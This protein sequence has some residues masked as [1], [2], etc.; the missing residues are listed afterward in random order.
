MCTW[1]DLISRWI[2][3]RDWSPSTDAR[4]RSSRTPSLSR[5]TTVSTLKFQSWS[6]EPRACSGRLAGALRLRRYRPRQIY[7]HPERQ[8]REQQRNELRGR[9]HEHRAALVAAVEL[10]DEARDGVEEHVE[11]ERAARERTPFAFGP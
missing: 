10:D 6:A 7:Q 9:E 1:P 3:D 2:C 4:K 11:P 5:G 8:G